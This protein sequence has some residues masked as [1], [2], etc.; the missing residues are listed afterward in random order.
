[1]F[2]LESFIDGNWIVICRQLNWWRLD[3]CTTSIALDFCYSQL[4]VETKP[5][6]GYNVLSS[7]H[8]NVQYTFHP[9]IVDDVMWNRAQ[10]DLV[11]LSFLVC[12]ETTGRKG[13]NN[14]MITVRA[15]FNL[16]GRD[17]EYPAIPCLGVKRKLEHGYTVLSSPHF[18]VQYTFHPN[19]VDDVM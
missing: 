10:L 9:N 15:T 8:F 4:G 5:E 18:N 14:E 3:S 19:I 1:M 13:K 16:K 12:Y 2:V 7:S 6:Y 17:R 11:V